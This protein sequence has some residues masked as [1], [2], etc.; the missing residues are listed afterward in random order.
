MQFKICMLITCCVGFPLFALVPPTSGSSTSTIGIRD[1][2]D[3]ITIEGTVTIA[4]ISQP[5]QDTILSTEVN[6]NTNNDF[7]ASETENSFTSR[8]ISGS[9]NAKSFI[10]AGLKEFS[11]QLPERYTKLGLSPERA[12]NKLTNYR[13]DSPYGK[14]T[15]ALEDLALKVNEEGPI[16]VA[17]DQTRIWIESFYTNGKTQKIKDAKGSYDRNLGIMFGTQYSDNGLVV[18]IYTG[19][20]GGDVHS[21]DDRRNRTGQNQQFTSL[22]HSKTWESGFRYDL[23]LQRVFC[24]EN[25]ERLDVRDSVAKGKRKS[26]TQNYNIE[27]SYRM[28]FDKGVSF[29]PN[30]GFNLSN[31]KIKAYQ[32]A[33]AINNYNYGRATS[34][35]REVYAGLGLRKEWREQEKDSLYVCKLTALYELGYE[36]LYDGSRVTS[37]NIGTGFSSETSSYSTGKLANYVTL[38]GSMQF[39]SFKVIASASATIMKNRQKNGGTLKLEWRF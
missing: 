10:R 18:G 16:K 33:E 5:P 21:S 22:Y 23:I 32:E 7:A 17:T 30:L 29:R 39:N 24:G 26:R 4:P 27:T 15:S 2:V 3:G 37:T 38:T 6:G 11:K 9:S 35:T 19:V 25:V 8:N 13:Q 20:A 1:T 12:F 34:L 36:L 31:Q 28:K 14:K